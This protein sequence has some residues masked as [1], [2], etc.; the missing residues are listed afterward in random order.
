M[1]ALRRI[2][3]EP[4]LSYLKPGHLKAAVLIA[5][6]FAVSLHGYVNTAFHRH[7]GHSSFRHLCRRKRDD[8]L[9]PFTGAFATRFDAAAVQQ[10]NF[11]H[12][13]QTDAETGTFL[14]PHL[15]KQIKNVGQRFGLD[16]SPGVADAQCD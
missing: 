13:A 8:E 12:D 7:S 4:V 6:T 15:R 16:S 5:A 1:T 9:T 14:R 3:C 11:A 10:H 2:T